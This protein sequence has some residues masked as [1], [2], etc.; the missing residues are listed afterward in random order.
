[1]VRLRAAL[2]AKKASQEAFDFCFKRTKA[3]CQLNPGIAAD[4]LIRALNHGPKSVPALRMGIEAGDALGEPSFTERC[5]SALERLDHDRKDSQVPES[6]TASSPP[7]F[8]SALSNEMY[9]VGS[10]TLTSSANL[11]ELDAA[12]SAASNGLLSVKC[13]QGSRFGRG[14]Y[15]PKALKKGTFLMQEKAA[16]V[17]CT[18]ENCCPVCLEELSGRK[19]FPCDGCGLLHCSEGCAM[20]GLTTF[21]AGQ[22]QN[23]EWELWKESVQTL[24]TF[25]KAGEG[26]LPS[27][28]QNAAKQLL[29]VGQICAVANMQSIH[30]RAL[31][32]IEHLGGQLDYDSRWMFMTIG[33]ATFSLASALRQ[34]HLYLEDVVALL[35][36]LNDNEIICNEGSMLFKLFSF[37]NHSCTPNAVLLPGEGTDKKITRKLFT[38]EE[39]RAGD[40]LLIDYTATMGHSNKKL[41]FVERQ[42]FLEA[43]HVHCTCSKCVRQM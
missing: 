17:S 16:F 25:S 19:G 40:Q 20:A 22:C 30:P 2:V 41:S 24:F 34:D 43:R 38:L 1:M 4:Y 7:H 33:G 9:R 31:P 32:F 42:A 35:A 18:K 27:R 3:L 13:P 12:V 21:H 23:K 29:H 14:L 37:L 8:S 11:K 5:K 6:N 28:D 15:A 26:S 39:V 10:P 36:I